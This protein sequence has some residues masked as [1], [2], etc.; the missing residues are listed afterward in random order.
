M[1]WKIVQYDLQKYSGAGQNNTKLTLLLYTSNM[2]NNFTY[3]KKSK[4]HLGFCE[5]NNISFD[6]I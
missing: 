6:D 1:C 3:L 4:Y 5:Q 2:G